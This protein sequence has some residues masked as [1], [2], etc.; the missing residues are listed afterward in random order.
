MTP[1]TVAVCRGCLRCGGRLLVTILPLHAW[2]SC[3]VASA[4]V[5]GARS[6]VACAARS[7]PSRALPAAEPSPGT[8]GS[9]A[10]AAVRPEQIEPAPSPVGFG[11]PMNLTGQT[12]A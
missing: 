5:G 1:S 6:P 9:G 2:C 8:G 10:R 4:D 11:S 3:A 12:W 7:L